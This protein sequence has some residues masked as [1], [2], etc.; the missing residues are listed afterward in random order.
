M[1]KN[2]LRTTFRNLLHNK[3]NFL[4]KL[5]GFTLAL[6]S[7]L[8]ITVYVSFH[9]S[10]D[11]H[12]EDY[13]NIYR[14]NAKWMENGTAE[15]YAV[16]PT[17]IG[18]AVKDAFPEVRAFARVGDP[19][20][21][22][23]KTDKR[24][25]HLYGF[26][27]ADS[28]IF[29]V[30][31]FHFIA[32]NKHAFSRPHAIVLTQ[33]TAL[34]LFGDE[35]PIGKTIS[36][37][38]Q[39]NVF[40]EVTGVIEDLPRNT[41]LDIRGIFQSYQSSVEQAKDPWQFNIDIMSYLYVKLTDEAEPGA[42]TSKMNRLV[43]TRLTPR[44][45]GLEKTMR[46][47]MMPITDIH[48]SRSMNMEFARKSNALYIYVFIALGIFLMAMASINYVNLSIVDF[49]RRIKEISVRKIL[50]ASRKGIAS[51][52]V[53]E[54]FLFCLLAMALSVAIVTLLSPGIFQMLDPDLRW[55]MLFDKQIMIL[56]TGVLVV[57][58]VASAAYPTYQLLAKNAVESLQN[59]QH[60][61][62]KSSLGSVLLVVQYTISIV[63]MCATIGV[64][65]QL[66]FIKLKAPGYDRK[67]IVVLRRPDYFPEDKIPVLKNELAALKGVE[68]VSYVTFTMAGGDYFKDWYRVE[69][70]GAMKPMLLSEVFFDHDFF[71]ATGLKI[72]AGRSFD[73]TNPADAHNAFIVNET[74]V[75]QFGWKDPIGKRIAYG[76]GEQTGEKWEGTVVGVAQDVNI[77]SLYEKIEPM[78]LRLP[79]SPWPGQLLYVRV[80]GN[81]NETIKAIKAKYEQVLPDFVMDYNLMDD[82]YDAQY[83]QENQAF[84]ILQWATWMIAL[85]SSMGIFSMSVYMT[86]KRMK[87]FGIR[88]MLGATMQEITALHLSRFIWMALLA[89]AIALPV[90]YLAMREWL[91]S[92]AYRNDGGGVAYLWVMLFSVVLVIASAGFSSLRAGSTK[93]LDVIKIQ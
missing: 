67:H 28:S 5:S 91:S 54:T 11:R 74:A 77:R 24:S 1:I 29:D 47:F 83:A 92:F 63:S 18:P 38:D 34:K 6:L 50:G 93:P 9:L 64:A 15:D 81:V 31:T 46:V 20:Q 85:I 80:N 48:L 16:V 66:R 59:R 72:V 68:A 57:L 84:T 43:K 86:M 90:A 51:Q 33:S 69:I 23:V 52:I 41:H 30:F 78:V 44:K 82:L 39:N 58:T 27:P 19:R 62:G 89:N 53:L 13:E 4:F 22:L 26:A 7:T 71:R 35:D 87:E 76:Y 2:Y 8:L 17:G 12:H 25:F 75:K 73:V 79:W 36:L 56:A 55:E 61:G 21:Y 60:F 88:K 10:F 37:V 40:F 14:V 65:Q 49:Q 32:G 3:A 42:L 45:D 70:D